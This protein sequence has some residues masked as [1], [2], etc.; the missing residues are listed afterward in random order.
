MP[1]T[2]AFYIVDGS[3]HFRAA[4]FALPPIFAADGSQVNAV[5]GFLSTLLKLIATRNPAALVVADDAPRPYFRHAL[6]PAYKGDKMRVPE[7]C[8]QQMSIL[9]PVL[10]SMRIPYIRSEGFEADD[11]IATLTR[12]AR[13]VGYRVFIC[14]RDKDLQQLLGDS[15]VILDPGSGEEQTRE[16]L[17]E[18]RGIPPHQ[19]PDMLALVGDRSDSIPGVPGVGPKTATTLLVAY[20]T[21]Q[22]VL[23]HWEQIGGK[24]GTALRRHRE[25]VLLGLKLATLR[26][27]V[28]IP[29]DDYRLRLPTASEIAPLFRKWGLAALLPRFEALCQPAISWDAQ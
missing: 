1:S 20:S 19:I 11:V 29:P 21:A 18:R 16:T 23:D 7:E 17:R 10:Q 15:V 28:P 12:I 14:S 3:Y 5:Y 6:F 13:A 4:F 9:R 25:Q 2:D 22:Q 26:F 27:D 24:V 8:D